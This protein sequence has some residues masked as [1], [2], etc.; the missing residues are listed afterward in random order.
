MDSCNLFLLLSTF[1]GGYDLYIIAIISPLEPERA[2]ESRWTVVASLI[3][4]WTSQSATS[5]NSAATGSKNINH[6]SRIKIDFYSTFL[7]KS[8]TFK[9]IM[10]VNMPFLE[11]GLHMIYYFYV[12]IGWW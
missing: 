3:Y 4:P 12:D 6:C 7:G 10:H 1:F 11:Y 8:K 9:T 2:A 5:F